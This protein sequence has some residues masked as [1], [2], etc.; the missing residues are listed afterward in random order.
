MRRRWWFLAFVG[1]SE[2]ARVSGS[3]HSL[4]VHLGLVAGVPVAGGLVGQLA[5]LQ[6]GCWL[7]VAGKKNTMSSVLVQL[8]ALPG[9]QQACRGLVGQLADLQVGCWLG[10]GWHETA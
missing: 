7:A 4:P 3:W 6:V 9:L 8:R 5:D 10:C 1:S 2:R